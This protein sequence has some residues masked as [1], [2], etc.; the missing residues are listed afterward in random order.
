VK[1]DTDCE[2]CQQGGEGR[3]CTCALWAT[4]RALRLPDSLFDASRP[5]PTPEEAQDWLIPVAVGVVFF[6]AACAFA[7]AYGAE[8]YIPFL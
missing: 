8:L 2:T 1:Q 7:I 3:G 5:M 4:R 6:A